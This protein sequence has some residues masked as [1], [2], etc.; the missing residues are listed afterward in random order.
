MFGQSKCK[1]PNPKF[2]TSKI[3]GFVP[4]DWSTFGTTVPPVV[5]TEW[6]SGQSQKGLNHIHISFSERFGKKELLP[7]ITSECLTKINCSRCLSNT[8]SSLF[9]S[10]I[11]LVVLTCALQTETC[12]NTLIFTE[13]DF[14]LKYFGAVIQTALKYLW[15]KIVPFYGTVPLLIH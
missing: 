3:R 11:T 1:G 13:A 2:I 10:G 9:T 14:S 15:V 12:H 7:D 4:S 6:C 5:T 8:G